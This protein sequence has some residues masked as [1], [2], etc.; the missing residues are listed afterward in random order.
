MLHFSYANLIENRWFWWARSLTLRIRFFFAKRIFNTVHGFQIETTQSRTLIDIVRITIP[1]LVFSIA[2]AFLLIWID[3]YLSTIIPS[4]R[5]AIPEDGDYGTLLATISGIGGI[6]I[7]LYYAGVTTVGS[8]IYARVPN[9]VR[10]LLA[11]E[12]VG[13]VYMRYLA[14]L[15]FLPL[16][17]LS[18]KVLGMPRVR[19]AIPVLA[20]MSGIGIVSFIKLGQRAFYLF[21]PTALSDSIFRELQ[22]LI[23]R[24]RVGGFGWNDATFQDHANKLAQSAIATMETLADISGSDKNLSARPFVAL[25]KQLLSFLIFYEH[26]KAKIPSDSRWYTRKVIHRD[27]YRTDDSSVSMAHQTGTTLSPD[28]VPDMN[29]VED[30]L[31]RIIS[32]CLVTN[33]RDRH[34]EIVF[35]LLP[36]YDAYI[37]SVS[38]QSNLERSLTLVE[39]LAKEIFSIIAKPEEVPVL[40]TETIESIGLVDY[41]A[42]LP[43]TCILAFIGSQASDDRLSISE[44]LGRMKWNQKTALY[45]SG[46]KIHLLKQLEWLQPR[47][48]F[49]F[50]AEGSWKTPLWY[51]ADIV[52]IEEAKKFANDVGVIFDRTLKIYQAW[53]ELFQLNKHPWLTAAV[54]GREW[55]YC[56]KIQAHLGKIEDA[57]NNLIAERKL[58]GLDWPV[59][60]PKQWNNSTDKFEKEIHRRMASVSTILS[61]SK[62]PENFPDYTGQFLHATGESV[63]TSFIKG[64]TEIVKTLFPA[65]FY[66][67]LKKFDALRPTST[68]GTDRSIAQIRIAGATLLDVVC[69]SGY[70]KLF[71]ELHSKEEIWTAVTDVWDKYLSTITPSPVPMFSAIMGLTESYFGISHRG[72]IRTQWTITVNNVLRELPRKDVIRGSSFI[73]AD[74]V[75]IHPSPLVGVF[76]HDSLGSFYDGE[77]IFAVFYLSKRPEGLSLSWGRK[78]TELEESIKRQETEDE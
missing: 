52:R 72:L 10:D 74:S 24:A 44:R 18:L 22:Q 67:C 32:R 77:D 65:F 30:Q 50:L 20:V 61:L 29:W 33:I 26:S 25:C 70:A 6:F 12:Q 78:T 39:G 4:S 59:L 54:I 36:Y 66:G 68:I 41:L 5:W 7:G 49:E 64:D 35:E 21:D 19:V 58:N 73:F 1:Q 34:Y 48:E 13:N 46:F 9:N 43:I 51:Q 45:T 15:T 56:H 8:S 47:L 69:L 11:R 3:V 57:W 63:L 55:E 23:K 16:T 42:T 37:K 2:V 53:T 62:R 76:A 17:L 60:D 31:L 27:W 38:E 71:A 40:E 75:A 28:S 14:F